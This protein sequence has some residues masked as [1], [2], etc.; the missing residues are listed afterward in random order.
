[1]Q[2]HTLVGP[3][4]MPVC[5]HAVFQNKLF[6]M[7]YQ[8]WT[9]PLGLLMRHRFVERKGG[10][11]NIQQIFLTRFATSIITKHFFDNF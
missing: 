5:V 6:S 3:V 7:H 4:Y 10:K 2:Q 9:N 8:V 11:K 1:M